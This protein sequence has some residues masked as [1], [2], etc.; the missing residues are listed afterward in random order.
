MPKKRPLRK[1]TVKASVSNID[2]TKAGT[3]ILLDV[4]FDK[5]KI[6]RV[7]LGKGSIRWYGKNKQ[8]PTPIPWSKF[9]AWMDTV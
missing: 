1:H 5:E 7:E 9:A 6:G 3:S 8:K 2:L 4:F